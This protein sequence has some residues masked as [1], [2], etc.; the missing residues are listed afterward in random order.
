MASPLQYYT[1]VKKLG[2][3]SFGS[4]YLVRDNRDGQQYVMKEIDLTTAGPKARKEALREVSFLNKL[5]HPAII[6]YKVSWA[7]LPFP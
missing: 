3:G 6:S 1:K 2:Q 5:S 7:F 4:V